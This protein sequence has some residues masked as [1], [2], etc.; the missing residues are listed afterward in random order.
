M[1]KTLQFSINA[2]KRLYESHS[3]G[4]HHYRE[5]I[6]NDCPLYEFAPIEAKNWIKQL[7]KKRILKTLFRTI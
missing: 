1:T 4:L 7:N 2:L 3:T 6:M 5:W